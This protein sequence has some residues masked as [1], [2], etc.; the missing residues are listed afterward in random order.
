MTGGV[1]LMGVGMMLVLGGGVAAVATL[2]GVQGRSDRGTTTA[3]DPHFVVKPIHAV[4]VVAGILG[5]LVTG[6]IAV[7]VGVFGAVLFVPA[8][9]GKST[10][11]EHITRLEALGSWTRRLA[12]LLAS[13][14]ASS[15]ERAL[16]KSAAIAPMA[17]STEVSALADRIGPQGT[18]TALMAFAQDMADPVSDEVVMS[19]ILQLRHG[20]RGLAAVLSDLAAHVEDQIRMRRGIEADR[21]KPRSN[22]RTIVLLTLGLSAGF[23]LLD[24]PFLEPYGTPVGQVAL[25]SVV[26]IF[27]V[28]MV[29][30]RRIVRLTPGERLLTDEDFAAGGRR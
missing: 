4:A 8:T 27:A 21:A 22:V 5:L 1:L 19:L 26:A 11:P 17:I 23:I 3:S 15:L 2:L 7:G 30:L 12:D 6:W 20:G 28:A 25:L 24:R 29:W 16:T 14:A 10:A 13:G 9:L 18:R